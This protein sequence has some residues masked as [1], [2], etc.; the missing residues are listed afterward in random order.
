MISFT[1]QWEQRQYASFKQRKGPREQELLSRRSA[2]E[3][4]SD[5]DSVN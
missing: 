5:N 3:H 2:K 4:N 1:Y